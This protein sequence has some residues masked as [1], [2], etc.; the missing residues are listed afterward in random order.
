MLSCNSPAQAAGRRN[1]KGTESVCNS[2]IH[3]DITEGRNGW[4]QHE[5]ESCCLPY[6][7]AFCC[8][9]PAL[10]LMVRAGL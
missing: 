1:H 3:L 9:T 8:A 4:V 6:S 5:N 2:Q 7:T 10:V